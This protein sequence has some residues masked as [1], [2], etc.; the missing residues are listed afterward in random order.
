MKLHNPLDQIPTPSAEPSMPELLFRSR[1]TMDEAEY[2]VATAAWVAD[3]VGE[4]RPRPYPALSEPVRLY[5]DQRVHGTRG[6][7][8]ELSRRLGVWIFTVL[9]LRA[10]NEADVSVF[11]WCRGKLAAVGLAGHL[12]RIDS[13]LAAYRAASYP[14]TIFERACGVQKQDAIERAYGARKGD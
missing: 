5:I 12:G 2:H 14:A 7:D 11:E 8:A 6:L 10:Q 4:Y 9:N 13:G 3:N 1:N